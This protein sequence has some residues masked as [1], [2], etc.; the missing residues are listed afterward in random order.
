MKPDGTVEAIGNV[1]VTSKSFMLN[2]PR[3]SYNKTNKVIIM[4]GPVE[5]VLTNI[6][7][8]VEKLK[9]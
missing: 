7:D 6:S 8:K 2:T 9:K 5:L 4:E 3:I 1:K